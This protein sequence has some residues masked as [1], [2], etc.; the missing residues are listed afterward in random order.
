MM[1]L[2]VLLGQ[3]FLTPTA[4]PP[5]WPTLVFSRL[6]YPGSGE[7]RTNRTREI[8]Q[9]TWF[10]NDSLEKVTTWYYQKLSI[11][12][13]FREGIASLPWPAGVKVT[14]A[15]GQQQWALVQDS[16]RGREPGSDRKIIREATLQQF[17]SRTP[18]YEVIIL[19]QRSPGDKQTMIT[20]T[21]VPR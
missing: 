7:G 14:E 10:T 6:H 12:P 17:F 18:E 5:R 16:I 19:V 20:I 2:A 4:L 9:G 1:V 3:S 15:R 21:T 13:A 8:A 11:A